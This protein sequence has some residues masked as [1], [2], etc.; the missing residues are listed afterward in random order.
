M[1]WTQIF[2]RLWF[3]LRV[4]FSNQHICGVCGDV[5]IKRRREIPERDVS[6][7]RYS[8]RWVDEFICVGC[9]EAKQAKL[10]EQNAQRKFDMEMHPEQY[11]VCEEPRTIVYHSS[12]YSKCEIHD[13]II[14]T[15]KNDIGYTTFQTQIK[16]ERVKR[17]E[18]FAKKM[19]ELEFG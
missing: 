1:T 9:E 17:A 4:R 11:L 8:T 13:N 7:L 12:D 10:V 3:V 5:E 14:Y 15:G 2:K 16:S 19:R 6:P 18:A